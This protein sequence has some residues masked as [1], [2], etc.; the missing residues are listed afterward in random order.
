MLAE[1]M[2]CAGDPKRFAAGEIGRTVEVPAYSAPG[3][4]DEAAL[5]RCAEGEVVTRLRRV[6]HL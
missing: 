2:R 1:M 3:R 5:A 6:A 4:I